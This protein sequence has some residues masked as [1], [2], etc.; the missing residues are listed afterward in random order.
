M[1]FAYAKL[2]VAW[3]LQVSIML[4]TFRDNI[5]DMLTVCIFFLYK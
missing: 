2:I 1:N 5:L 4:D 3:L